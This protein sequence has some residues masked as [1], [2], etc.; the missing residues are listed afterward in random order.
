ML[1]D[2]LVPIAGDLVI[3]LM[4][5]SVLSIPE[6][7]YKLTTAFIVRWRNHQRKSN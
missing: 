4:T 1:R 7:I 3:G 5:L 2:V 6:G